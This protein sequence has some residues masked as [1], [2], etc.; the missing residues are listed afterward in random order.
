MGPRAFTLQAI[1][2][3][4]RPLLP[5]TAMSYKGSRLHQEYRGTGEG[6]CPLS[7]AAFGCRHSTRGSTAGM[8]KHSRFKR[9]T[10][11]LNPSLNK[12]SAVKLLISSSHVNQPFHGPRE[13]VYHCVS[14]VVTLLKLPADKNRSG[15]KGTPSNP[16]QFWPSRTRWMNRLEK[17]LSAG[18]IV[19]SS[20]AGLNDSKRQR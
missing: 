6:Q 14:D 7:E 20:P 12:I 15:A 18:T 16:A 4:A 1:C 3:V 13:N 17:L 5:F 19:P 10:T 9:I 11:P 8:Y 2:L